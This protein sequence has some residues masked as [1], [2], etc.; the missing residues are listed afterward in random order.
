VVRVRPLNEMELA[1]GDTAD[2]VCCLDDRVVQV[3]GARQ[4]TFDAAFGGPDQ[5]QVFERTEMLA[6]LD[7]SLQGYAATVFAY[8]QT[9]SGKTYTMSGPE[10][11]G[12]LG[13]SSGAPAPATWTGTPAE[14]II[15]RAVRH[16]FSALDSYQ[17]NRGPGVSYA[18][19]ASYLEIYNEQIND[20]LNP[21]STGLP[22]RWHAAQGFFVE[23]LVVIDCESIDELMM[24]FQEG[25]KNRK[26]RARP[27]AR[28]ELRATRAARHCA[29][30]RTAAVA[31]SP[32]PNAHPHRGRCRCA[33]AAHR[34]GRIDRCPPA[35]GCADT[36]VPQSAWRASRFDSGLVACACGLLPASASA[37]ACG[38]GEGQPQGGGG[39]LVHMGCC[40][41]VSA[42]A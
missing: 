14:G 9:G 31:A 26:A 33:D 1:R 25:T 17:S 11:I 23:G 40:R 37:C 22:V 21:A 42:S 5:A 36:R 16:L 35:C 3:G 10:M 39:P 34:G 15:P 29:G 13:D 41:T 24:V 7:A 18:I 32:S 20:L 2:G 12:E 19:S 28:R 4:L 38:R 8:G 30:A 27:C 6:L